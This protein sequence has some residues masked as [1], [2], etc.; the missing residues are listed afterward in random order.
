[1]KLKRNR[2]VIPLDNARADEQGHVRAHRSGRAGRILGIIGVVLVVILI[3][4]AVGGYFWWRQY[5]SQPAYSLAL[6]VD[7]A[8][9]NDAA[10][11]D[12][13]LDMDKI[14][15]DFVAQVKARV[16]GSSQ[17]PAQA[18]SLIAT[19]TPKLK[20]TMRDELIQEI[21]RLTVRANGKPFPLLALAVPYFVHIKQDGNAATSEMKLQD[22][23]INLRMQADAAGRWQI[24]AVQDDKLA[25][26]IAD[27]VRKNLPKSPSQWQDEMEKQLKSL[28][29]PTP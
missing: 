5:Q 7:A 12:R 27:R 17:L 14:T 8:Q 9:R 21:Q 24:V 19:L 6:L 2:I 4:A 22:E 23:Q 3:G 25:G 29:L 15:A 1:M 16:P 13:L 10:E 11:M 26:L 28:S 18:D 20:P